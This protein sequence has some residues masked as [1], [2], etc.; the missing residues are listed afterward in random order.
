MNVTERKPGRKLRER[1]ERAARLGPR[2][3]GAYPDTTVT[4]DY[5]TPLELLVATVLSAQC[6]DERVNRVTPALFQRYR[7][8][9]DYARADRDELEELIRPT[10]FFRNKARHIQGLATHIAEHHGGEVPATMDE[11]TRLPG[12]ARKTANV[13]LS[14][15]FGKLEGVVVDTHVKR[16]AGRLGLTAHVDPEKVELDL[17]DVLP[18]E[19]WHRFAWRLILHGRNRCLARRPDCAGCELAEYCPS[20]FAFKR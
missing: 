17:M 15:V 5:Q 14:N 2:L 12:V 18:R 1:R 4:L 6:T 20:A 16:V 8:A 9:A 11:L 13:V 3:A 19:E 10:G 7:S